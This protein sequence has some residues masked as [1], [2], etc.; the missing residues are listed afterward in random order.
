[1][2]AAGSCFFGIVPPLA[3]PLE[4]QI[5]DDDQVD[6]LLVEDSIGSHAWSLI[7]SNVVPHVH[8]P[9]PY[10]LLLLFLP[11]CRVEDVRSWH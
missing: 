11:S 4:A 6:L 5:R 2:V 9:S 8:S 1:M 7:L 3:S 10:P